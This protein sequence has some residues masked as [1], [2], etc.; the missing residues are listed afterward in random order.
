MQDSLAVLDMQMR[1]SRK[2]L[3][4]SKVWVDLLHLLEPPRMR[5]YG[6]RGRDHG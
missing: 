4:F 6:G 5:K 2:Q 3:A 1:F